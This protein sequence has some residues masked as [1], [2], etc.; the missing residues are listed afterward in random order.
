MIN[1]LNT[2]CPENKVHPSGLGR[3]CGLS[4]VSIQGDGCCEHWEAVV[5]CEL[6]KRVNLPLV[7]Y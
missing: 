3:T 1:C 7:K 6:L 2:K 4:I 5:E